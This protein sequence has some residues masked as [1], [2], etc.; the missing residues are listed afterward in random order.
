MP[1]ENAP[2]AVLPRV[3]PNVNIGYRCVRASP[4]KVEKSACRGGFA[5]EPALGEPQMNSRSSRDFLLYVIAVVSLMLTL[6]LLGYFGPSPTRFLALGYLAAMVGSMRVG[7]NP[8]SLGLTLIGT[9]FLALGVVNA[10]ARTLLLASRL[11]LT[12]TARWPVFF[13]INVI[14]LSVAGWAVELNGKL[15]IPSLFPME[16]VGDAQNYS[17][18]VS[19]IG[20]LSLVVVAS[21][22][23]LLAI[24]WGSPLWSARFGKTDAGPSA[25]PINP[26]SSTRGYGM[27]FRT[28]SQFAMLLGLIFLAYAGFQ[29]ATNQPDRPDPTNR[30]IGNW[31]D[32]QG[33]NMARADRRNAART[34]ALIGAVILFAGIAVYFSA[35]P[36]Q[37]T[38]R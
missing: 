36:E 15:A 34:P 5:S 22:L 13:G 9:T 26:V 27:N 21:A 38:N 32:V 35:R 8:V 10:V 11:G 16:A 33:E 3:D 14:L 17:W 25:P 2:L 29:Y 20:L 24:L 37:A 12:A 31:L 7:I 6:L 30:S 4:A 19:Q 1:S 18:H 23:A 28:L